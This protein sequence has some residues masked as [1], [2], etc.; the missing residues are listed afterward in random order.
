MK[1]YAVLFGIL[2][3]GI[4]FFMIS[5]YSLYDK[6]IDCKPIYKEQH[7]V[8]CPRKVISSKPTKITLANNK[9]T[10][11]ISIYHDNSIINNKGFVNELM[12]KPPDRST[13]YEFGFNEITSPSIPLNDICEDTTNLPIGNINVKFLLENKEAKL[14]L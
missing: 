9:K 10:H 11:N 13:D 2:I 12:Y 4:T 1:T 14:I 6:C 5:S 8:R 7:V 3:T